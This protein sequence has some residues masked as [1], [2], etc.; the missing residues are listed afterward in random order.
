MLRDR[1]FRMVG[2]GCLLAAGLL[3][4]ERLGLANPL[5]PGQSA[6][7]ALLRM[8]STFFG[9]PL[10]V[11]SFMVG[12]ALRLFTQSDSGRR[13]SNIA[14][15]IGFCLLALFVLGHLIPF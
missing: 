12:A 10:A 14:F 13:K 3:L 1:R 6:T 9:V 15:G 2:Q 5:A 4:P 7:V 11:I 8:Y